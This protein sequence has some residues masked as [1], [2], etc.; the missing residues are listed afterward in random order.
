MYEKR[1]NN[2]A[3]KCKFC[4]KEYENKSHAPTIY[5]SHKCANNA[6]S[7]IRQRRTILICEYCHKKFEVVNGDLSY[8]KVIR[9]CS[10]QCRNSGTKQP[11]KWTL[12]NCSNCGSPVSKLKI[13]TSKVVNAFCGNE[14]RNIYYAKN[15]P[16]KSQNWGLLVSN[17]MNNS[18][19]KTKLS[20]LNSRKRQPMKDEHK[21]KISDKLFGIMPKNSNESQYTKYL[22]GTYNING[23]DI[24][25][26]SKW[27]ANYALY[28]DFLIKQ[29]HIIS[30]AYEPQIFYF[31][32][33]K[34]GC[35]SYTPDFKVI[36]QNGYEWHEV[37]GYMDD[38]SKTKLN[39]MRIYYPNEI[40]KLI[41]KDTYNDIHKKLGS[42][43]HMF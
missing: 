13:R 28:L 25:F 8:R 23:K 15:H 35:R 2:T 12:I 34:R 17:A 7:T 32:S 14:C 24:F 42:V 11:D 20:A 5:C 40:V 29:K 37:K 1:Y 43:L 38:K 21:N 31:E 3:Q 4:G 10:L 16:S 26:R 18:L 22:R 27:E 19:I 39:R 30:W 9:F 6:S 36:I 41:T 33:I